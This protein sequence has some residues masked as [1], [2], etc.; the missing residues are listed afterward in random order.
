VTEPGCARKLRVSIRAR[1][2]G[3]GKAGFA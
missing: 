1:G 2:M 3:A